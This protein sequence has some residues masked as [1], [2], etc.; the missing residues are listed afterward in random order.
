MFVAPVVVNL[1]RLVTDRGKTPDT[2]DEGAGEI[3]KVEDDGEDTKLK[4]QVDVKLGGTDPF[5]AFK[6]PQDR[7]TDLALHHWIH[8]FQNTRMPTNPRQPWMSINLSDQTLL[9]V[10]VYCSIN[11]FFF[12]RGQRCPQAYL[13]R[14]LHAIQNIN[15]ELQ[16]LPSD[17]AMVAVAVMT[18]LECLGG[19]PA[20]WVVHRQ[21]L[22]LM[23]RSRGGLE[24]LGLEGSV[25]RVISWAD[26]CCAILLRTA[27]TLHPTLIPNALE[28]A[29]P[30]FSIGNL[31]ARLDPLTASSHLTSGIIYIYLRLRYLSQLLLSI[32]TPTLTSSSSSSPTVLDQSF[33]SDKVD[34]IERAILSLLCSSDLA[35]SVSAAFLTAFLNAALI[36]VY[37]D[38]REVPKWNNVSILLSQ[39][40]KSGLE[41]AELEGVMR[42]CPDLLL[43]TLMLGMSGA[44]PLEV[45]ARGWFVGEIGWVEGVVGIEGKVPRGLKAILGIRYFELAEG[46]GES[47]DG[48]AGDEGG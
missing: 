32:P 23:I 25:Q 45:G 19:E 38:L 40:I 15:K 5:N 10:T 33:F 4:P 3:G 1:S 13:P 20:E 26:T 21:G 14:K 47:V 9:S 29:I 42:W 17:H 22:Q 12:I 39:R 11:H 48:D 44:N 37:E 46:V 7:T 6:L 36:F 28:P 2:E 41:L 30:G 8:V 18:L 34:L 16:R 43:W 24:N 35:S 31:A 27:P